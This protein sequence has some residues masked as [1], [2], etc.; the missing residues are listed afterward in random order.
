M[1][2]IKPSPTRLTAEREA[3]LRALVEY[4]L[5]QPAVRELFQELDAVRA[6]LDEARKALAQ[7]EWQKRI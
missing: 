2:E 3:Y 4:D 6:E 7:F 1:N 5:T